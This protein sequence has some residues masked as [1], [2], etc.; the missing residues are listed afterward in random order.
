MNIKNIKLLTLLNKERKRN[1]YTMRTK[2]IHG[3]DDNDNF[4]D[5]LMRHRQI[6]N[7]CV[8]FKFSEN[9]LAG[10][11]LAL[12]PFCKKHEQSEYLSCCPSDC[13]KSM[14]NFYAC[15]NCIYYGEFKTIHEMD[16]ESSER[17]EPPVI[18]CVRR[19]FNCEADGYE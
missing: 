5:C 4:S 13:S 15:T 14:E 16:S 19:C 6:D 18:E 8:E 9:E 10:R 1:N 17:W 2:I 12:K 11:W 7:D 3:I